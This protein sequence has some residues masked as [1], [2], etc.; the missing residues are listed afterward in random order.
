[1][2]I[3]GMGRVCGI[4]CM[5]R[6]HVYSTTV[7]IKYRALPA[8]TIPQCTVRRSKDSSRPD[9]VVLPASCTRR[10]I[11]VTWVWVCVSSMGMGGD[12]G[13]GGVI[14]HRMMGE[15]CEAPP[16]KEDTRTCVHKQS[17]KTLVVTTDETPRQSTWWW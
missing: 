15:V 2:T 16:Y 10:S 8:I 6:Y 1:M 7:S 17:K 11:E 13:G 12:L 9:A 4:M 14:I 3:V 5:I